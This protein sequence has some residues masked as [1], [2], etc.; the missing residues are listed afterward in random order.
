VS[1]SSGGEDEVS[2]NQDDES[3]TPEVPRLNEGQKLHLR[4]SCEYMDKMLQAIEGILHSQ[5]SASPFSKYLI[6]ISP[7][8]GRVMEDYIRRFRSQI[9]RVF[10]WQG[11]ELPPPRIPATRSI[12]T[13]LHFIDIAISELRPYSMRGSGPMAESTAAE[14]MGVLRELASISQN[15]MAYMNFELGESLQQRIEKLSSEGKGSALLQRIEQV[16]TSR[17]LVEYRPRLDMLLARLEDP[18]FEVAVFGR[19][20]AGKSSFLNALLG[21]DLLPVGANPIT[22]VPTR[23]QYGPQVEAQVRLGN[24]SP[25]AVSLQRFQELVSEAGNPGNQEGVRRASIEAPCPRL[26]EGIVLVDTPGLGSLALK[27]SRETLAYLP[28]CDLAL[29]LIDAGNTLTPEDIGTLRLIL[30][31]GIPAL[32]LLSKADLLREPDRASSTQ[33]IEA[34]IERELRTH[35]PVHA[36]SSLPEYRSTVDEFYEKELEPR[37]RKSHELRKRSVDTKLARLQHDIVTTLET[38]LRRSESVASVDQSQYTSMEKSLTEV[39]AQLGTGERTLVERIL[40]LEAEAPTLIN[41]IAEQNATAPQ[42][43]SLSGISLEDLSRAIEDRV[44][45]EVGEMVGALHQT[46][47]IVVDKVTEIGRTLKSSGVPDTNEILG[48]IRDAPRFELPSQAGSVDLG[49]ARHLG[50]RFIQKRLVRSMQTSLQPLVHRELM[51]YGRAMEVWAKSVAR[52]IQFAVN[53]FADVYRASLQETAGSSS[54]SE[55]PAALREDI[56]TLNLEPAGDHL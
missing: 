15:M 24:T 23:I 37:F 5:E 45:T 40:A 27:G 30:E 22:A 19:V 52:D 48:I 56:A 50:V 17:G 3:I 33:Y 26:L 28:S 43:G 42:G 34:Q 25:M 46:T 1:I 14:L 6:D 47:Q 39:A 29:L 38:R 2:T 11:V 31:A 13:H 51:A 10:A 49:L 54:A 4:V 20:S 35:L 53:S 8:Q 41:R 36:L 44:Q 32:V 7:A 12:T 21:I 16:V 18:T 55:D 9:L